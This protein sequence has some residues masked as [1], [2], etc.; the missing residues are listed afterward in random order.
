MLESF[1][2]SSK[3]LIEMKKICITRFRND[4]YLKRKLGLSETQSIDVAIYI[5]DFFD[6]LLKGTKEKVPI[7][8]SKYLLFI[9][10]IQEQSPLIVRQSKQRVSKL[11][12]EK[13]SADKTAQ[14]LVTTVSDN[15]IYSNTDELA[16]YTNI[17]PLS[18]NYFVTYMQQLLFIKSVRDAYIDMEKIESSKKIL[19]NEKEEKIVEII[20]KIFPVIE[21]CI[22]FIM[23]GGDYPWDSRFKYQYRAS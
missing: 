5:K 12:K 11:T 8:V 7:N 13:N 16:T 19:K 9:K 18:E 4:A 2:V 17:L 14:E 1:P 21:D 10:F 22:R 23:L 15:I 20:Q 6:K 3:I